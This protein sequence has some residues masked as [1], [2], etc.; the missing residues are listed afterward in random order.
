MGCP[1]CVYLNIKDKGPEVRFSAKSLLDMPYVQYGSFHYIK[2]YF[3]KAL[4]VSMFPHISILMCTIF[5]RLCIDMWYR[6]GWEIFI[7]FIPT[8]SKEK[9]QSM[10]A[11]GFCATWKNELHMFVQSSRTLFWLTFVD[12]SLSEVTQET[13]ILKQGDVRQTKLQSDRPIALDSGCRKCLTTD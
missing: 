11:A 3:H 2:Q 10:F 6:S 9:I 12:H 1:L 8:I 4:I 13:N 7:S 5:Y